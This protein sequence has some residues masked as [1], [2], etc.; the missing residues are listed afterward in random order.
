MSTLVYSDPRWLDHDPGPGHPESPARLAAVL[1]HLAAHPV[2][3]VEIAAA[4]EAS[5]QELA[6]VHE[7]WHIDRLRSFDGLVADL[8]A[9]TRMS[10]GSY[11][12]ACLAAGA[13]V[14]AVTRV[15]RHEAD[16]AFVLCRPPGHH[17]ERGR[18]M[19]FCLYNNIAI[20]AEAGL[21]LGAERV[22]IVDWDVHH[23]NGTQHA[24]ESRRDV[25]FV[26]THQYPLYPGT[27]ASHE[28][29]KAEGAGYTV[30][31]ALPEG[32]TDA[33]YGAVFSDLVLPVAEAYAPDLVLVSAGFDAH[34]ADPLG[35]MRLGE[36]G[37]AAMTS[38]LVKVAGATA[39]GR[40]VLMLEGGYELSAL[41]ASVHACL[42]VLAG[43]KAETF[44][45]TGAARAGRAL[46][47]TRD[48]LGGYWRLP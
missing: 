6:A 31:C 40:L 2:R 45:T 23:G 21:R 14:E 20:A 11:T 3:G 42:E 5:D 36:R 1:G 35:G 37:F 26:S 10:S 28:V 15:W 39:R 22:L 47:A 7:P 48:A 13:A 18:A 24:F 29:G 16:N 30:N 43:A 34:A 8:D 12:A 27:G 44:P 46:R 41:S 4:R 9:D 17:A 25:L 19:G 33:D 32:Q 38:A